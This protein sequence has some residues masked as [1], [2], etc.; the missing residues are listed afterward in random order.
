MNVKLVIEEKD[1]VRSTTI[2]L[3][4][5]VEINKLLFNIAR[6]LEESVGKH[7]DDAKKA[8]YNGEIDAL[9]AIS[10]TAQQENLLFE[11]VDRAANRYEV[12]LNANKREEQS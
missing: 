4:P 6:F 1:P 3:P 12:L 9:A 2:A 5:S 7:L 10:K 8:A 11:A